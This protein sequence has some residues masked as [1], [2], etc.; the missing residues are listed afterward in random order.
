MSQPPWAARGRDGWAV[1]PYSQAG[2][3]AGGHT[4]LFSVVLRSAD[5]WVAELGMQGCRREGGSGPGEIG[6]AAVTDPPALTLKNNPAHSHGSPAVRWAPHA[7]GC[8]GLTQAP[9]ISVCIVPVA[10]SSSLWSVQAAARSVSRLLRRRKWAGTS[11]L[12]WS[13]LVFPGPEPSHMITPAAKEAG[14]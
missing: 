8:S 5:S 12:P 10:S 11:T 13:F 7:P 14:G 9:P 6:R 3:T 1:P 4:P 2:E